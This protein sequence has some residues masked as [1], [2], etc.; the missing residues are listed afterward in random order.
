M[1]ALGDIAIKVTA[2]SAYLLDTDDTFGAVGPLVPTFTAPRRFI[3]DTVKSATLTVKGTRR[4]QIKITT[5][6]DG[7]NL[8]LI[9]ETRSSTGVSSKD[10]GLSTQPLEIQ[11][12]ATPCVVEF[13]V[14][15]GIDGNR[16]EV[17]GPYNVPVHAPLSISGTFPDGQENVVY[18]ASLNLAGIGGDSI[19]F[20]SGELP[21]GL[22][23]NDGDLTGTPTTAGT[24]PFTT[25]LVDTY[26][27]AV[28]YLDHVVTIAP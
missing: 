13:L 27:N 18:A 19:W 6:E 4:P 21:P 26:D 8:P 20:I 2:G 10:H 12:V 17:W 11:G 24:Y 3:V 16:T 28:R 1:A 14:N 5:R 15:G 7:F 22:S 25:I 23:F 9:V